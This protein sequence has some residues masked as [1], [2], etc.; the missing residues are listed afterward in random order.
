MQVTGC[1]TQS[2]PE[3]ADHVGSLVDT[4][5]VYALIELGKAFAHLESGPA[6]GKIVVQIGG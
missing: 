6:K 5:D 4:S 1:V 2:N 3:R